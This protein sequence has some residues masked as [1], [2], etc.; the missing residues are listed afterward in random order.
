VRALL[1]GRQRR[2]RGRLLLFP[3]ILRGRRLLPGWRFL[4]PMRCRRRR[5]CLVCGRF[6]SRRP[7]RRCRGSRFDSRTG[8]LRLRRSGLLPGRRL[9]RFGRRRRMTGRASGHLVSLSGIC[10]CR[11]P[12]LN[13]LQQFFFRSYFLLCSHIT[14]FS[15]KTSFRIM[16]PALARQMRR[17]QQT[18]P[19]PKPDQAGLNTRF[20]YVI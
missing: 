13:D 17:T 10:L 2:L 20:K 11:T 12:A 18:R 4:L 3:P 8:R 14:S 15:R 19:C 1:L 6:L 5:G 16:R 9:L 7:D